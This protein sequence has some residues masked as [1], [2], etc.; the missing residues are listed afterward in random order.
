LARNVPVFTGG[1]KSAEFRVNTAIFEFVASRQLANWGALSLGIDRGWGWRDLDTGTTTPQDDAFDVGEV[2]ARFDIDTFD[3]LNFPNKGTRSTFELR[4]SDDVFGGDEDFYSGTGAVIV[5]RTWDKNTVLGG[6]EIGVTFDGTAPTQNL[7]PLGGFVNLSG[8][9]ADEL[10]GQD[11]ALGRLV[12]YRNIGSRPGS[13]GVPVYLGASLE[14]GNVW[15]DRNDIDLEDLIVAG[16][17]FVGLDTPLGPFY[18]AYGHAEGGKNS[19]YMFLGQ[20]F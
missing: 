19:A 9:M 10:S 18:I 13:F 14:A 7:F 1:S 17:L 20:T 4:R 3:N 6:A 16:S 11:F 12:Y 15:Q 2:F 8:Y 5:A